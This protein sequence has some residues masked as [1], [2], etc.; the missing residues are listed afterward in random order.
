MEH[1]IYV[2]PNSE[3]EQYLLKLLSKAYSRTHEGFHGYLGSLSGLLYNTYSF[4]DGTYSEIRK[5][6]E[7][8]EL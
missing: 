5:I 6:L 7:E 4:S 3:A 2:E 8:E 1:V